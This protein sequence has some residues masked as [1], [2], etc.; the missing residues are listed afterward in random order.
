ML[1]PSRPSSVPP[2]PMIETPLAATCA[3]TS[4]APSARRRLCEIS[5]TLTVGVSLMAMLALF[6]DAERESA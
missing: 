2:T 5:T 1:V 4:A 6:D 3:A